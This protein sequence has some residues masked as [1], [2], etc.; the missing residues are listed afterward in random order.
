MIGPGENSH[1]A[2]KRDRR[3]ERTEERIGALVAV[4]GVEVP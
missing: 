2:F 1:A 4:S 3:K